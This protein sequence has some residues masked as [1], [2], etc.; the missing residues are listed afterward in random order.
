MKGWAI[1]KAADLLREKGFRSFYI[2]AGGDVQ[3]YG[4][5]SLEKPWRI[6]IRNPFD[7]KQFVKVVTIADKGIATSG[8][9]ERGAHVYDPV[10]KKKLDEIVSLTVIGSN[11]Y[12]A[13]RFA[14][15][16]FA[17]GR[18]GIEF[19]EQLA[20]FEAYQIDKNGQAAYTSGFENYVL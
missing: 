8:T 9:Y 10:T 17:M 13:D 19:I 2:D 18:K 3:V 6:G 1:Q 4:K 7:A 16:A 12:E 14:T 15:A 20:G 5:N 11:V